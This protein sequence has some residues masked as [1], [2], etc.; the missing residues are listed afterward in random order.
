[1]NIRMAKGYVLTVFS[2]L[3]LLAAALLL[4]LQAQNRAEFSLYGK[5]ISIRYQEDGG[6]VGGVNTAVLMLSSA[7]GGV[8]ALLLG[9]VLVRGIRL[10]RRGWKQ[11]EA[12]QASKR[13]EALEKARKREDA[14]SQG[15]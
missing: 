14:E 7:V 15:A 1:M 11:S 2:G 3:L 13:I 6:P 8:G 9:W 5:N 12:A 4:I 10:L